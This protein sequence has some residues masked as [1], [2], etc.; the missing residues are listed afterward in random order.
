M[1]SRSKVSRGDLEA[2]RRYGIRYSIHRGELFIDARD[3]RK[4][5]RLCEEGKLP[6]SVC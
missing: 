4:Y 5:D 6:R 3:W 2:L 1:A